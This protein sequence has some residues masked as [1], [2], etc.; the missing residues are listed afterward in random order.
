MPKRDPCILVI[1]GASGD[2][3]KLKLLPALYKLAS[4]KLLPDDLVLVGY[5][6][7]KMSDDD[8]RQRFR[9]A[10]TD[11]HD[12]DPELIDD[13]CSRTYYHAGQYDAADDFAALGK[14]L[15]E[16]DAKHATKGNRLFYLSTP[17]ST[18]TPVVDQL[19]DAGL[20]ERRHP[21]DTD[22]DRWTRVVI[23]KPFG[24]DLATARK[25]NE[26]LHGRLDESQIY[27]IDHYLG[28]E[29]V[30]NMMVLRFANAIFEPL[31][32]HNFVDHVQI[33]VAE[34]V[35]ADDRAG[36][37]DKSGA[38]RDMVQNH[39]LQLVALTAMEPPAGLDHKHT[40]D[41]KVKVFQ[42]IRPIR[43]SQAAHYA[44]RGQYGPGEFGG[45]K[46]TG[47]YTSA[48][49]VGDGTTTETFAAMKFYV[50]N[51]RWSGTPFYVRTGKCLPSKVS[52]IGVRFKNPPLTLF[53]KQCESPVYPNDLVIHVAPKGGIS[54]RVN[55]KVPG[56]ALS[57]KPVAFDF[58]YSA[59]FEKEPPEAYER[60]I[61]DA[62]AG[63]QS[64][65]IRGDEAE[66]AWQVVDPV[67]R[68]WS[69]LDASGK[70]PET[71]APGTWG[72]KAATE[73]LARD[74]RSWMQDNSEPQPVIAC[75]L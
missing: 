54:M 11:K 69:E 49:G 41:E 27:R 6:R 4:Q 57:I 38:L 68:G 66:A 42:S 50:D 67:L 52:E 30:Q 65:F 15:D 7:T 26:D 3:A 35:S 71:Y 12:C 62:I 70:G 60:L 44:V 73:L 8:F 23:E 64:L 10:A 33:T 14:R 36:Y 5:S 25:L 56:N 31:W 46:S 17:P 19:G 51:W 74:G 22:A 20:V 55:G 37:Y 45:G 9:E 58:D 53:Q 43:Q 72:P 32:N 63:D 61:A 59:T 28:K 29:L 18:F 34:S 21:D 48:K 40:R 2:L 13:L 1:F 16:L 24:Y 75:A 47:G 39:I